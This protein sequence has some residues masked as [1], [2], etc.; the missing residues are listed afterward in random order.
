M[1]YAQ[2]DRQNVV[3]VHSMLLG[4]GRPLSLVGAPAPQ[5]PCT[6]PHTNRYFGYG[7]ETRIFK[8]CTDPHAPDRIS[9]EVYPIPAAFVRD[10]RQPLLQI[11]GP[12]RLDGRPPVYVLR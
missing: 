5:V 2:I 8:S 6:V 3:D 7:C 9:S 10:S 4:L 12:S 11:G 1:S